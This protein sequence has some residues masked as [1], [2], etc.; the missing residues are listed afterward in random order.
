LTGLTRAVMYAGT[1][2]TV[3]SLW[4][5]H[6]VGTKELMVRF[7]RKLLQEKLAKD[8]ALRSAKREMLA[9]PEYASP[10]YWAAFV[11]YGE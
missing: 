7:Y 8:G 2:A 1:P 5:V 3:V 6:D 11:M 4:S 10:Y 9:S